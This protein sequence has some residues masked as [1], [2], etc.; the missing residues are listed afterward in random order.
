MKKDKKG[1]KLEQ[2]H[3]DGKSRGL[4]RADLARIVKVWP[5]RADIDR[6]VT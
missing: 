5:D 1:K 6:S 4:T 3:R 2:D